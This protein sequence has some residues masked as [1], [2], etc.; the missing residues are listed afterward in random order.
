[1]ICGKGNIVYSSL[2][3]ARLL[4]GDEWQIHYGF[5][6]SEQTQIKGKSNLEHAEILGIKSFC[7]DCY[8]DFAN[9]AI[10][11]APDYILFAQFSVIIKQDLIAKFTN[12]IVNLHYG[13]LPKYRGSA[14]V[15]N[16]LLRGEELLGVTLHFVDQQI[17]T[18]AIILQ[19][20]FDI[21][22][23]VNVQVFDLCEQKGKVIVTNF[24]QMIK[25]NVSLQAVPQNDSGATYFAKKTVDY[26]NPVINFHQSSQQILNFCRAFYFPSRNLFPK[27]QIKEEAFTVKSMPI[28]ALRDS[29]QAGTIIS[30]N[31]LKVATKDCALIFDV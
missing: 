22:E 12:K 1:M 30:R 8:R 15:T 14:P 16:A 18:G 13:N 4:L 29:T 11:V 10:D 19:E 17:D 27:I 9:Y 23:M 5:I 3:A 21:K 25:D 24:L 6:A 26:Q 31:P 20:E 28:L 7:I 2:S